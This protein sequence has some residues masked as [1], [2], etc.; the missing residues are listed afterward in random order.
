MDLDSLAKK[1]T[2]HGCCIIL[3]GISLTLIRVICAIT[4]G[5][6]FFVRSQEYPEEELEEIVTIESRQDILRSC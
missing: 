5:F 4:T 6:V 3:T 1:T 2:K